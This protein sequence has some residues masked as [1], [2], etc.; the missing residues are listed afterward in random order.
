[1]I[2]DVHDECDSDSGRR[3]GNACTLG[4]HMPRP[5]SAVVA[6]VWPRRADAGA[7]GAGIPAPKTKPAPAVPP[8]AQPDD[9]ARR[10]YRVSLGPWSGDF[11]VP[12]WLDVLDLT[13]RV[14]G[15][16]G[17]FAILAVAVFLSDNRRAISRRVVFWGLALQWGLA[18]LVL[19]VPAGVQVV[20]PGRQDGRVDPELRAGRR[21][22]RLRRSSGQA[23]RDPPASSSPFRSCRPS[24]SSRPCSRSC[25][26]WE[27]CSGSSAASRSSWPS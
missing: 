19:R 2:S 8:A 17:M 12:E 24:S 20:R 6:I 13:D 18:I 22:V 21:Q 1:M 27:S 23:R 5:A 16:V 7:A 15:F 4:D 10:S 25:T 9:E 26:T 11:S 3:A 14:R